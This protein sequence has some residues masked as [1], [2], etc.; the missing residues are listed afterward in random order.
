MLVTLRGIGH[1]REY[2][3]DEPHAVDLPEGATLGDLLIRIEQDFKE[4]L[5][6]SIWNW[7]GHRFRGPVVIVLGGRIVK[8]RT[9]PLQDQQEVCIHKALVGG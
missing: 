7:E 1:M 5:T 2:L 9:T 8:D 6:G 3:G 4:Q